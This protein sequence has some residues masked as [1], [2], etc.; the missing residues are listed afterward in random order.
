MTGWTWRGGA[1]VREVA[2]ERRPGGAARPLVIGGL[3]AGILVAAGVFL[4]VLSA[5]AAAPQRDWGALVAGF[6]P[7][8]LVLC[9]GVLCFLAAIITLIASR[10]RNR[11]E[12]WLL[13]QPDPVI[14]LERDGIRAVALNDRGTR[15]Q[16]NVFV[17]WA[18]IAE[19]A[20]GPGEQLGLR[21][22]PG[23][24]V[25]DAGSGEALPV[26]VDRLRTGGAELDAAVIAQ[27]LADPHRRRTLLTPDALDRVREA[28]ELA[29]VPVA[30]NRGR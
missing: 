16:A 4:F 22:F 2:P 13:S 6:L 7:A 1:L 19:V 28:A 30:D 21:L 17:P 29:G 12:Q 8:W 18:S 5:T 27:L 23:G 9:V 3:I 26:P 10:V 24:S 20:A 11:R 25:F 14:S 15:E